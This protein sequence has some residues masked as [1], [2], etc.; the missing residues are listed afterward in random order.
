VIF[1]EVEHKTLKKLVL[2][3]YNPKRPLFVS[4]T[5]GIGKSWVIKETAEEI[6]K[7]E[8]RQ[9]LEWNKISDKE[10]LAICENKAKRDSTLLFCDQRVSQMDP[11]DLRGLPK[12]NGKDWVEWKPNLLFAVLALDG[13]HA[14]LFFDEL[15]LAPPSVQAAAYQIILD[16]CIGELALNPDICIIAAGNRLEDRANV[17]EMSSPLKNRFTHITLRIPT[18]QEWVDWGFQNQID[19]RIISYIQ[20][21][22]S[23]MMADLNK[24][25]DTKSAAFATP[26]S[27][28]FCSELIAGETNLEDLQT[29]VSASVG[30]GI[31]IEFT[32]FLRLREKIDLDKILDKPEMAKGLEIDMK[33]SLISA[34]SEKY[35]ANKKILD[36]TLGVCMFLEPD[37][38]IS[39]L[40]MLKRQNEKD[41]VKNVVLCPTWKKI[42]PKYGKYLSDSETE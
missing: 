11:S 40:R 18:Y 21:K 14:V 17:Y 23:H 2:K 5:T 24:A 41:F 29:Y 25:K 38:S 39:L 35:R 4:G 37:F 10:K 12:L 32:A 8:G 1:V 20:F 19:D 34:V 31:G 33:W 30:D 42:F 15:N 27:W 22:P 26:R 9:F 13:I 28:A 6:A 16:K 36:K 3:S 7:K